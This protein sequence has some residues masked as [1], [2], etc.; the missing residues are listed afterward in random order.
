M[1]WCRIEK[2]L[3]LLTLHVNGKIYR[4]QDNLRHQQFGHWVKL[5]GN[6]SANRSAQS[7]KNCCV[8]KHGHVLATINPFL[9]KQA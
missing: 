9:H 1:V 5:K 2:V 4:P 7:F 8:I 6:S 3:K